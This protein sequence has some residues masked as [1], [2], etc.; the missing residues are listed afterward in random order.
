VTSTRS[1]PACFYVWQRQAFEPLSVALEDRRTRRDE[2]SDAAAHQRTI[3]QLQ[4]QLQKK[5]EIIAFVSE[6]HLA[7]KKTWGS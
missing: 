6:E 3:E 4:A 2:S 1:S 7:L 5:D